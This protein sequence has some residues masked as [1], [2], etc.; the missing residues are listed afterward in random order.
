[1]ESLI[2]LFHHYGVWIVF[3]WVLAESLGIPLPS[4]P[5][6][7]AVGALAAAGETGLSRPLL[8]AVVATMIG[9]VVWYVIGRRKGRPVLHLLCRLSMN[10]DACI[11]QTENIFQRYGPAS[12]LFAKFIPGL[13]AVTA[14]VAGHVRMPQRKF[15]LFDLV[16]SVIWAASL[17]SLGYILRQEVHRLG[18]SLHFANQTFLAILLLSLAGVLAYKC[19]NHLRRQREKAIPKIDHETLYRLLQS[20]Q[21]VLILDVRDPVQLDPD[22]LKIKNAIHVPVS[23]V[24]RYADEMPRGQ[25][26]IVYCA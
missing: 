1:M 21:S 5:L 2:A 14:P 6:L 24:L 11:L 26:V 23:E 3:A 20:G 4:L 8:A 15:I 19:L 22:S 17:L 13:S 16:G 25:S 18:P 10:P 9:D 12:L 7:L